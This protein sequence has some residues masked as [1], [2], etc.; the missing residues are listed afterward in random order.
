MSEVKLYLGDCLEILPTLA[1]GSVD[2]VVTDPPYSSGARQANQ[3]RSRGS[4]LRGE[5][6]VTEWMG[7]DNLSSIGFMFFMRG[8]GL[9]LF[10]RCKPGAHLYSFIDWRNYPLL[11]QVFES[12]GWRINNLIVWN[13]K[14]MGMGD[15]Y[16]NQ[17]ELIILGS[18][19]SP[20]GSFRH[21]IANVI[22]SRRV[23]QDN[24][25]TEKPISLIKIM[26]QVSTEEGDLVL[27]PFMGSGTTGVACV[28]TGRDF[29]G[30]EIDPTYYAI[31]EKRIKEAQMQLRMDI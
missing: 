8:L 22:D 6:W 20:R 14:I 21:D 27:D 23:K 16:R 29:I 10:E 26:L 17:H 31:A 30:I 25:P 24:H 11:S 19:G 12:A 3:L 18:K 28:Q 4:M 5:K 7:T 15:G 1:A 2:A 9:V 13:K